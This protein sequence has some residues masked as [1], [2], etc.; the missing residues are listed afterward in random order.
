MKLRKVVISLT[1]ASMIYFGIQTYKK[2]EYKGLLKESV[3]IKIDSV[4]DNSP[5]ITN[6]EF[7][8][9]THM[10]LKNPSYYKGGIE[11]IVEKSMEKTDVIVIMTH[12]KGNSESLD[13]E[14]F[15]SYVKQDQK[16]EVKDYGKYLEIK[17]EKDKLIAIKAQE[18]RLENGRDILAIGCD[19]IIEPYEDVKKTIKK[20]HEQ[21]GISI[22]AHPMSIAKNSFFG[23]NLADENERKGLELICDEADALEEFNSQNYLWLIYSNVLA[24][25]FIKR[26]DL[27]G[28]AGS[29]THYDLEQ[30]GLSGIIVEKDLLRKDYFVEDL[31]NVIKNKKFRTHKEYTDPIKFY[32]IMALPI[33]KNKLESLFL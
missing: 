6:E 25:S 27:P 23:I 14:T 10:H 31:K 32:K 7:Y 29:D 28:T 1:A 21:N 8:I 9:D 12:N 18:L 33:L 3:K 16:Y 19:D 22:I 13:Y 5:K 2:P 11:E 30:I 15:K 20:I 26:H 24:E 4:V 17:T